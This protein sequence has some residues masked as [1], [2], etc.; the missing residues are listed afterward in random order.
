MDAKADLAKVK[1]Q[2]APGTCVV[3][4]MW[5]YGGFAYDIAGRTEVS[6]PHV[7]GEV[8]PGATP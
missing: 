2:A 8:E 1:A 3:L 4:D 7:V 6:T 5:D